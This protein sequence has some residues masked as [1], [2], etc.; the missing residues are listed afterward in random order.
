ME[1]T[2]IEPNSRFTEWEFQLFLDFQTTDFPLW[3]YSD[4]LFIF[5]YVFYS[6]Y[7]VSSGI[8]NWDLWKILY[9]NVRRNSKVLGICSLKWML[10]FSVLFHD[11]KEKQTQQHPFLERFFYSLIIPYYSVCYVI[12]N[13]NL[14]VHPIAAR[15]SRNDWAEPL[16]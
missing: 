1:F 16:G 3:K 4:N 13:N 14:K 6:I 7:A 10:Q 11:G 9:C 5:V 12:F 15:A 8:P 2:M